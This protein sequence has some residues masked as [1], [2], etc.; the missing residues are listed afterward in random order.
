MNKPSIPT[1]DSSKPLPEQ[2]PVSCGSKHREKEVVDDGAGV[3]ADVDGSVTQTQPPNAVFAPP[4]TEV[5]YI[6]I[7]GLVL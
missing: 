5:K 1:V 3:V 4:P 7:R 6:E 2:F